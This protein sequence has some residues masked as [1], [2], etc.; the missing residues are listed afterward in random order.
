MPTSICRSGRLASS[1]CPTAPAFHLPRSGRAPTP[2]RPSRRQPLC[3][4]LP[5]VEPIGK[6]RPLPLVRQQERKLH[7][8]WPNEL[9]KVGKKPL[10]GSRVVLEEFFVFPGF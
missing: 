7:K 3:G 9:E 4:Q 10:P 6:G 2:P 1:P 8:T 5:D